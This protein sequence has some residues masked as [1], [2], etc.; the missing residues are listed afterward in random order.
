MKLKLKD[1]QEDAVDR[2]VAELRE[3]SSDANRRSQSVELT[4]PTGS[5][6]TVIATAAI[7]RIIFGDGLFGPDPEATFLWLSDQPTLNEQTKRKMTDLSSKLR[8]EDL[9][10]IAGG[11]NAEVLPPGRVHFL[12]IQKIGRDKDLVTKDDDRDN[13]IWEVIANT[14]AARGAHFFLFIDEAHRGMQENARQRNVATSITQRFIKGADNDL[15]PPVPI[16][17]GISATPERFNALLAG[18]N[19]IRRSVVVDVA[20]VRESGLLKEAIDIHLPDADQAEMTMLRNAATQWRKYWRHWDAYCAKEKEPTVR[21]LLV[22]QVEDGPGNQLSRTDIVEAMRVIRDAAGDPSDPLTTNAFAHAFEGGA[23]KT[24]GGEEVRY[25][26]PPDIVGDPELRVIFF[27]TSLNTGWDCPRAEAMMSFRPAQDATSIAQLVGRMVRTPLARRIDS[28]RLLNTVSLHLPRYDANGL[29]AI[30]DRLTGDDPDAAPIEVRIAKVVV[31]LRKAPDSDALF[32]ALEQI[33]SE[34]VPRKRRSSEV[35]RLMKFARLLANDG[36]DED[37]LTTATVTIVD[38]L[39]DEYRKAEQSERF[40]R[41]VARQGTVEIQSWFVPIAGGGEGAHMAGAP[42]EVRLAAEDVD[43][44]FA[45]TG[46]K[47]GDGLHLAWWKRRVAEDPGGRSNAKLELFALCTDGAALLRIEKAAQARSQEWLNK[48]RPA[49]LRLSEAQ[50][51]LYDEV[52]HL[53]T[54]LQDTTLQYDPTIEV[55]RDPMAWKKHVYVDETGTYPA[56]LNTWEIA[57]LKE[58]LAR[59]DFAGWLRNLPRKRWSMTVSYNLRGDLRP[60][61]PDFLV[62]RKSGAGLVVDV[63]EPHDWTR[64]DGPRKAAGLAQF[65]KRHWEQFGRIEI[66]HVDKDDHLW[67]LRLNDEDTRDVVAGVETTNALLELFK[68]G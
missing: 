64:E 21:P 38:A 28:D 1:F 22:V 57:T 11:F 20:D 34:I 46:R 55:T 12:N 62:I 65:A 15:P 63:L 49:L 51:Q 54:E 19:R 43:A 53:A 23:P 30:V 40:Q 31:E 18:T 9:V 60:F 45:A 58:E 68:R 44:L 10:L 48:W 39:L 61:Y 37:A 42:T 2:L 25:L 16:I 66:I 56:K 27:K 32:A 5:G 13:T 14:V 52:K 3:A 41:I 59:K 26:A 7:E 50:K 29:K 8:N 4:S 67:R 35:R 24:I 36:I 47:L 33:P 17:V 6:K